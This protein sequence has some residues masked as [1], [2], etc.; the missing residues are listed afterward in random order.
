MKPQSRRIDMLQ[1]TGM[2]IDNFGPYKGVNEIDFTDKSGVSIFWGDN[3]RGKTTLLNAFRYALFG[4]VQRRHGTLMIMREMENYES[5]NDGVYGFSISIR[6]QNGDDQYLLTRSFKPRAGVVTPRSDADYERLVYLKKNGGLLSPEQRDHTLAVLM[7]EQVSRFFLFDG[8]LLQ[9]YE[10]LVID[11]AN[12]GER[13]KESI[14]KILGVPV[15]QNGTIDLE[16]LKADCERATMRIAQKNDRT[17]RLAAQLSGIEE[18]IAEH[19]REIDEMRDKVERLSVERT[20]VSTEVQKT[21]QI[22]TWITQR[23]T[24]RSEV[25]RFDKRE[26]ELLQQIKETTS[27]CWC[28]M[29]ADRINEAIRLISISIQGL[30]KKKQTRYVADKFIAEMRTACADKRCPVCSQSV[31]G[32]ILDLLLEQIS[33]SESKFAG[34]TEEEAD[35]LLVLQ[36]QVASLKRLSV[37]DK[38]DVLAAYEKQLAELRISRGAVQQEIANLQKKIDNYE[39]ENGA[40]TEVTTLT[41]RLA[42][43]ESKILNLNNA[44]AEEK[45]KRDEATQQ[46]NK[47]LEQINKATSTGELA[48]ASRKQK[49][50]DDVFAIFNEGIDTYSRRLKENVQRDATELFTRIANDKAY[51]GLRIND[52]YGLNIVLQDGTVVPGRSA[53]YEHVVALSLIGALHKNAPLQGPI[54][55]DSPFGRLDPTHKRN[56]VSV[57]PTMANQVML[58]VYTDEIDE[59]LTRESLA[60]NLISEKRLTRISSMHTRIE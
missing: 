56:I 59:Q 13:I 51:V 27:I 9:E 32:H 5:R 49:L 40:A 60:G 47:L 20:S 23:D 38:K 54:I 24:K 50:C 17:K 29:L 44:I 28:G 22:R 48:V 18:E 36:A 53:G 16:S 14:E 45:K 30:E 46:K 31:E 10:G 42:Q 57:L 21:E 15:L 19:T 33:A 41:Q 35:E 37:M 6:M 2:T 52:N 55:M 7:P 3:G 39:E 8:E 12:S 4:S 34:L 25:A 26:E 43:V 58:L 1:F 11:E